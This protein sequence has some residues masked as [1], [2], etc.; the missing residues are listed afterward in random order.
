MTCVGRPGRG[1]GGVPTDRLFVRRMPDYRPFL[2]TG[3]FFG[4]RHGFAKLSTELHMRRTGDREALL[5]LPQSGRPLDPNSIGVVFNPTPVTPAWGA[6]CQQALGAPT[7]EC[8]S[9]GQVAF[10]NTGD[11]SVRLTV[12]LSV[13][14]TAAVRRLTFGGATHAIGRAPRPSTATVVL[15]ARAVKTIALRGP[16]LGFTIV[17]VKVARAR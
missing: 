3:Q 6:G 7:V 9:R 5:D 4:A 8:G 12:T 16:R 13:R 11:Q 1:R 2:V 14:T 17:D 15:P 10:T